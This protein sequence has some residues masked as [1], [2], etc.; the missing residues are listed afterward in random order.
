MKYAG[1]NVVIDAECPPDH[2]YIVDTAVIFPS[3]DSARKVSE[4]DVRKAAVMVRLN[5]AQT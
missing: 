2:F 4:E 5:G 3:A 1:L